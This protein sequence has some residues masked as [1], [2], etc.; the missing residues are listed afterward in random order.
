MKIFDLIYGGA[1]YLNELKEIFPDA[2]I[3]DASDE[4][5]EE[6]ISIKLESEELE[7]LKKMIQNGFFELSFFVSSEP[8]SRSKYD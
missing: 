4:I 5:H 1:K 3:K 7:Y 8:S 6:R 2:I